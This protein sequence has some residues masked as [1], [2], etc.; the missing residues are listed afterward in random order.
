MKEKNHSKIWQDTTV[1][2]EL[3]RE[4]P[5][6][7]A[8]IT[9]LDADGDAIGSSLG[10]LKLLNNIGHACKVI[11]PNEYPGFLKWLPGNQHILNFDESP[12]NVR[13]VLQQA[14]I[15]FALDFNELKRIKE[16]NQLLIA[17]SSYKILIDH[18]PQPDKFVDCV[19]SDISAS[20][21]AELIYRFI[22][23]TGLQDYIDKDVA[24]CLYTGIM[25]DTGCFSYNS[26][27]RETYKIVAELLDYGIDKDKI[28]YRVYDNFSFERL[29]LLGY[30]LNKRMVVLPEYRTAFIWL[31]REDLSEYHFKVGDSEGFVNYPLSIRGIRFSAFFIEKEDHIKISFRSKGNFAANKFS[32]KYFNGGGHFNAS[33]GES[34]MPME[35][36]IRRF[37][38]LLPA[39]KNELLDYED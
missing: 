33:G 19:L 5:K 28:Y 9:H 31:T 16:I 29:R 2:A 11:S 26:S 1:I 27:N 20:S 21:T 25:T 36:T 39:Y 4:P 15:I 3:L 24:T 35:E 23:E 22:Q 7:I 10:L 6:P 18:H 8:I 12:D 30:S 38:E 17:T 34:Y 14:R 32:R 37:K 13:E